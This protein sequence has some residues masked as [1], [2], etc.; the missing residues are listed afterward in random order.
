MACMSGQ[1]CRVQ[2]GAGRTP[3]YLLG[4]ESRV[5]SSRRKQVLGPV[6]NPSI[7]HYCILRVVLK[8]CRVNIGINSPWHGTF[9]EHGEDV[10]TAPAPGVA[11]PIEHAVEVNWIKLPACSD[12][13]HIFVK[14]CNQAA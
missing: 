1:W 3:P 11:T 2:V 10:R 12:R 6:E 4:A 9:F 13:R 8:F 5:Q 7:K 14:A